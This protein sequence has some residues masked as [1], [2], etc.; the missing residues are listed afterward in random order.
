[1]KGREELNRSKRTKQTKRQQL[2]KMDRVSGRGQ[3]DQV[4][5]VRGG[6]GLCQYMGA[7]ASVRRGLGAERR[8]RGGK[9]QHFGLHEGEIRQTC[10]HFGRLLAQV[11]LFPR[12]PV[13]QEETHDNTRCHRSDHTPAHQRNTETPLKRTRFNRNIHLLFVATHTNIN[14]FLPGELHE[15]TFRK[16]WCLWWSVTLCRTKKSTFVL[17]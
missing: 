10:D 3:M 12:L 14:M 5:V 11:L 4:G 2:Y 9:H 6:R 1:M 17:N 15:S 8:Q 13:K 16:W 7:G